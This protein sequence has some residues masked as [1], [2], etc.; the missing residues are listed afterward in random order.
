MSRRKLIKLIYIELSL[1]FFLSF[2]FVCFYFF[3]H[4]NSK[5]QSNLLNEVVIDNSLV[6]ANDGLNNENTNSSINSINKGKNTNKIN[7]ERMLKVKKL[8]ET[9]SDIVG[10]LE[11]ENTN[12]N[13]PILQG[14]DNDF[15]L[16]HDY[17]KSYYIGGSLFLDKNYS[18]SIPNTNL[19]IYGHNMD[20]G[21]MFQ[22]L[23]KYQNK[24]FYEKHPIIRFTTA[25]E[26]AIYEIIAAFRS[27]VYYVTDKVFKYYKF[28]H[29]E[30]ESE[31]NDYVTNVKAISCYDTGKTAKY[32]QQLITLS[33]CS[34]HTKDGRFAVVARKKKD[35]F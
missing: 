20:D 15:Y 1:L 10:W 3:E 6:L 12:I 5:K 32:G 31:Y 14:E 23:L 16:D 9:N 4:F 19:L 17:K 35:N 28:I 13:Y 18:W 26:D 21:T 29:A 30:N 25:K 33:T 22:D 11:I 7:T 34:Y 24:K 8:Q 2:L 27:K